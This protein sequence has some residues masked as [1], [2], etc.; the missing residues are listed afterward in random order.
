MVKIGKLVKKGINQEWA[1]TWVQGNDGSVQFSPISGPTYVSEVRPGYG[2][3]ANNFPGFSYPSQQEGSTGFNAGLYKPD[4]AVGTQANSGY[5]Y[6]QPTLYIGDNEQCGGKGG[7]CQ[8]WT[9]PDPPFRLS[10]RELDVSSCSL[11]FNRLRV[12]PHRPPLVSFEI[13][14]MSSPMSSNYKQLFWDL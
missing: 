14:C 9:R 13:S 8:V 3:Q 11:S 12:P 6:T 2:V 7:E 10:F 1:R 5:T 4:H